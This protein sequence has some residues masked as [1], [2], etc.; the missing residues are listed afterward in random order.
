[1]VTGATGLIGNNVIQ[2]LLTKGI[3]VKAL[4]RSTSNIKSLP[5]N[6]ELSYGDIADRSS[7]NEA[8]K[9]CNIIFHTAGMFAYWG[10]E[11]KQFIDEAK[12]GMENVIAAAS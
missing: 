10:Y 9:D 3:A 8:A 7:L 2:K 4:V 1:L 5:E 11:N 12:Q 6:I